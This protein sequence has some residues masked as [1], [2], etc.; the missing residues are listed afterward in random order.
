M[1][2]DSNH[3]RVLRMRLSLLNGVVPEYYRTAT[4]NF[5]R[6]SSFRWMFFSVWFAS[7][8]CASGN[9]C[10]Y[11]VVHP[12]RR[13]IVTTEI[14]SP[15]PWSAEC[16]MSSADC[17]SN[18]PLESQQSLLSRPPPSGIAIDRSQ[19]FAAV[20]Y[21]SRVCVVFKTLTTYCAPATCAIMFTERHGS[22]TQLLFD[23][24]VYTMV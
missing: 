4:N 21:R 13:R 8:N 16:R 18:A 6:W 5:G 7:S 19:R 14:A 24:I 10:D 11:V 9:Y 17:R 12:V 2:F 22:R 23:F 3:P 20:H 1:N 15:L